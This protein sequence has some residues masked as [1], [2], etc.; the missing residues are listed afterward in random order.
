MRDLIDLN[1]EAVRLAAIERHL[2]RLIAQAQA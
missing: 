1:R 2:R